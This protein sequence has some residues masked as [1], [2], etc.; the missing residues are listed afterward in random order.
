MVVRGVLQVC[1][2]QA[3]LLFFDHHILALFDNGVHLDT[4]VVHLFYTIEALD[5]DLEPCNQC[6]LASRILDDEAHDSDSTHV[7]VL[8][9][10]FVR[11]V[12]VAQTYNSSHQDDT[13][14]V[15]GL[16]GIGLED[17]TLEDVNSD[18]ADEVVVDNDHDQDDCEVVGN[19][20]DDS[21]GLELVHLRTG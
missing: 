18:H 1:R 16:D 4:I 6:L 12:M 14:E 13:H 3:S 17:G 20:E 21:S 10:D 15:D 19:H 11:D 9:S 8:R 5:D 7:L 2:M